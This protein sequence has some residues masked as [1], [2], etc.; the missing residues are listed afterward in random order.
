MG[1]FWQE[2]EFHYLNFLRTPSRIHET[3]SS[4]QSEF[5]FCSLHSP[6]VTCAGV[7][8]FNDFMT[9]Q[10]RTE[11]CIKSKLLSHLR[12]VAREPQ[13]KHHFSR[14]EMKIMIISPASRV[15]R[16]ILKID[17]NNFLFSL[18]VTLSLRFSFSPSE[19]KVEDSEAGTG[20]PINLSHFTMKHAIYARR[21]AKNPKLSLED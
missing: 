12:V 20:I 9:R 4:A 10:A 17:S 5:L 2:I 11:K 14:P 8:I 18:H 13:R 7:K 6:T 1:R 15:G 3:E 21:Y 19:S 16:G